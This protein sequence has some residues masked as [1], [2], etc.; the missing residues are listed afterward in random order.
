M[1]KDAIFRIYSD[2]QTDGLGRGDDVG[3]GRQNS[4]HDRYRNFYPR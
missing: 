4:A 3:R 2:D 1:A